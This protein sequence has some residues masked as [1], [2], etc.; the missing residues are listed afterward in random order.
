MSTIKDKDFAS[1]AEFFRCT[2]VYFIKFMQGSAAEVNSEILDSVIAEGRRECIQDKFQPFS[3]SHK[4]L[5]IL[6]A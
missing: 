4:L 3:D 6:K 2:A 1:K 5:K